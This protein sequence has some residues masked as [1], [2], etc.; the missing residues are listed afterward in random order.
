MSSPPSSVSSPSLEPASPLDEEQALH[1][2]EDQEW[3]HVNG[4]Y[5][6][7]HQWRSWDQPVIL[8]NDFDGS[9]LV[10]LPYIDADGHPSLMPPALTT[11]ADELLDQKQA[12]SSNGS[13]PPSR[14]AVHA[15]QENSLQDWPVDAD[16]KRPDDEA[17]D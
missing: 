8:D 5:D 12:A 9:T 17:N 10:V 1:R 14:D 3:D 15:S 13:W 6:G 11:T 2:I 4:Q 7:S 16:G